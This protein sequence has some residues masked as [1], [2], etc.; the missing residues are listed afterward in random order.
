[1]LLKV[2]CVRSSITQLAS[3]QTDRCCVSRPLIRQHILNQQEFPIPA[4]PHF[5]QFS[6]RITVCAELIYSL[7]YSKTLRITAFRFICPFAPPEL[8]VDHKDARTRQCLLSPSIRILASINNFLCQHLCDNN[9]GGTAE[10]LRVLGY[11]TQEGGHAL[12]LQSPLFF[13]SCTHLL[14]FFRPG[15]SFYLLFFTHHYIHFSHFTI[16]SQ[17]TTCSSSQFSFPCLSSLPSSRL[18]RTSS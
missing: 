18:P 10:Y 6:H 4:L 11:I 8:L 12:V 15:A 13:L 2:D 17:S 1:M 7:N 3:Q 16:L 14:L 9:I 5:S